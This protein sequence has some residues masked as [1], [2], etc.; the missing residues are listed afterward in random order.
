MSDFQ[1]R[2]FVF[3]DF[4]NLK[5]VK[6]KKLE[7]VCDRVFILIDAKEKSIPF[8]L[9]QQIQ[10]LG[11]SVRWIP[12]Q[13][14]INGDLNLHIAFLMGKFHQKIDKQTE[15]AVL[16]NSNAFDP[17]VS[18]INL[19]GRSCLRVRS[20]A[21]N[22]TPRKEATVVRT[23]TTSSE[24]TETG[25]QSQDQDRPIFDAAF[26]NGIVASTATDTVQ[27][28]KRTGNRPVEISML[29]SYIL[30]HNQEL[31]KRGNVDE[32]IEEMERSKD[33]AIRE[34][35]VTYHF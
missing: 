21:V 27:R 28:L 22:G 31:T 13:K 32:I 16:S 9:V 6:F 14:P 4:E 19:Q 24:T 33:I 1:K 17:L 5:K 10:R 11:K 35:E 26:K 20:K 34:G 18:Y 12:I 8:S 25:V 15:F 30:L 2:R 29:R 23:T 3:I 7:K